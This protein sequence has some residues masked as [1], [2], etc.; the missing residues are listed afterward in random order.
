MLCQ[1]SF[2]NFKSYK[3]ETTF[4]FQAETAIHE[5][6][7]T[8][9][10]TPKGT[11]LLP[12]GVIYG[13]NG[14]GK[15]NLLQAF[16]CLVT[17]VVSPMIVLEKT[18]QPVVLIH[19][20]TDFT[21]LSFLFDDISNRE[22]TAFQV[23]F[24]ID[25][26]EYQYYLSLLNDEIVY[27]SLYWKK[28]GGRKVGTVFERDRQDISLGTVI[29][30]SSVNRSVNPRMP[31]LS[32]LAINYDIPVIAKVQEWFES[33]IIRNYSLS[34]TESAVKPEQ[35][36]RNKDKI[37]LALNDMDID[38]TDLRF[39]DNNRLYTRRSIN[40]HTFELSKSDESSGTQK[41]IAL[42]PTVLMALEEGRLFV[43][44]ELD[45]KLHPKLIRYIISL[46]KNP[47]INKHGAQLW[48][49]SHDVTTMTNTVFRRDE[50]WFAALAD[51][52]KSEIY[53]LSEIRQENNSN[54]KSTAAFN[55]QYL[56]GR[57]GADPYLSNMIYGGDWK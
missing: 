39:D 9:I 44:D 31:Y 19:S 30:K 50:I 18:R 54:I 21:P 32:F 49:T 3:D 55:K 25:D 6:D 15:S 7:D 5:F 46:F 22:P 23:A 12:V 11:P 26:T 27:E 14:G 47:D 51:D 56:E 45:A 10:S 48:F 28:I 42:L 33:C 17:K 36:E 29:N 43:Y 8:L 16:A 53:S 1:F 34:S 20:F 38:V 41:L 37:I 52:H 57:Y 40:G 35:V 2:S 4:D 13:P 24:R